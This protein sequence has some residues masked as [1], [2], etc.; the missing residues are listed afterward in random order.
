MEM[1][2]MEKLYLALLNEA[3]RVELPEDL[4]KKAQEPLNKM[5]KLSPPPV[6][7]AQAAAE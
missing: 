2:T 6:K 1:N 5:M 3:P 4:R 7:Q